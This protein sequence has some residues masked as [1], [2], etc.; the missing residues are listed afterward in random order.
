MRSLPLLVLALLIVSHS[1]A[2]YPWS[3]PVPLTSGNDR[4]VHP[5]IADAGWWIFGEE[6]MMACSR[7]GKD[8]L[9]LRT[10]NNGSQWTAPVAITTD[11]ADND[12]PKLVMSLPH[13]GN[14]TTA[15]LVWQGRRNGNLDILYSTYS[16]SGW[17]VPAPVAT[18]PEDDRHPFVAYTEP[19][20]VVA[21]EQRG[22]IL[23]SE[24]W[25]GAWSSP[26]ILSSSGDTLNGNPQ[27]GYLNLITS[28]TPVVLWE[29]RKA[30]DSTYAM[31]YAIR[32]DTTWRAADTVIYSGNNRSPRF[33]KLTRWFGRA[34]V[35]WEAFA[36]GVP[37]AKAGSGAVSDG[38]FT[39]SDVDNLTSEVSNQRNIT[40]NGYSIITNSPLVTPFAVA[41]WES[42]GGFVDSIAVARAWQ[43]R[44][45]RLSGPGAISN[46][47]PDVSSGVVLGG[48]ARI[49]TVWEAETATSTHLYGSNVLIDI[50]GVREEYLPNRGF[51]L[52]QNYPN[53]FNPATAIVFK[54]PYRTFITLTIHDVLGR[55]VARLVNREMVPGVYRE[56]FEG[57]EL[58]SGVYFYRLNGGGVTL[59][60]KLLLIR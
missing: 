45:T 18:T 23:A 22:K 59:T 27:V 33:Y 24:Y 14:T 17:S 11:S 50:G 9:L 37:T 43:S 47:N 19:T 1:Y 38:R 16:Q 7:N 48:V 5:A 29:R 32:Q 46:R 8:I 55:E 12:L 57:K 21:W 39:L 53:P 58:A 49:W 4:Y 52:F 26:T 3:A 60:K 6:E 54:V 25:L 20:F 13:G 15:M 51:D 44:G 31:M 42:P 10:T 28:P 40:V 2:Q 30:P 34:A 35:H 56:I 41:A 36:A